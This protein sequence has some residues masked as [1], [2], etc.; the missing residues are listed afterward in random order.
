MSHECHT[1]RR[2]VRRFRRYNRRGGTFHSAGTEDLHNQ[3]E[4][5]LCLAVSVIRNPGSDIQKLAKG[6][7]VAP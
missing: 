2:E 7:S 3:L 4:T 6:S 1:R 5:G